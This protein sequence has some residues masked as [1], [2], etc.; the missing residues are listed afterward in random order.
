MAQS[1]NDVNE[2]FR[3]NRKIFDTLKGEDDL[4]Y[5]NMMMKFSAMKKKLTEAQ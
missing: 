5:S 2:I 1:P 4:A 3:V